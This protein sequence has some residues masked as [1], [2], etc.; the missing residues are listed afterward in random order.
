[1]QKVYWGLTCFAEP[2]SDLESKVK[3][4]IDEKLGAGMRKVLAF[5][6]KFLEMCFLF[7]VIAIVIRA[8]AAWAL[9]RSDEWHFEL[10]TGR[11]IWE[12]ELMSTE[13]QALSSV[14]E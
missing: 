1:M 10:F 13:K 7:P 3:D 9:G 4:D 14:F 8:L 12:E 5:A 2:V 11:D 6:A